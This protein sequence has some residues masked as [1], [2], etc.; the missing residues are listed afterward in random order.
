VASVKPRDSK[1]VADGKGRTPD[2]SSQHTM[3]CVVTEIFLHL[4]IIP[5]FGIE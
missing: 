3:R 5:C 4:F 1:E 2:Y